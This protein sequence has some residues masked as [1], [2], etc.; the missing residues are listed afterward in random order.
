MQ[1]Y[2]QPPGGSL[3][4][5]PGNP[6]GDPFGDP[7]GEDPLNNNPLDP[8]NDPLDPLIPGMGQDPLIT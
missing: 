7:F 8:L 1:G 2:E 5:T 3:G 4:A 6:F